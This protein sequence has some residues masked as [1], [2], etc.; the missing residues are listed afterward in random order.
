MLDAA[1]NLYRPENL[2][3]VKEW[4]KQL[5]SQH[6][7]TVDCGS[8]LLD[9]PQ[10]EAIEKAIRETPEKVRDEGG[11]HWYGMDRGVYDWLFV[12]RTRRLECELSLLPFSR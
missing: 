2:S 12:C 1:Y 6:I 4:M 7:D 8:S 11:Q 5:P 3:A 10:V 9:A